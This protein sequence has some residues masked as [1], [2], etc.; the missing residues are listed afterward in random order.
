MLVE[1]ISPIDTRKQNQ[2]CPKCD[3]PAKYKIGAA[4]PTGMD[5]LG[6]SGYR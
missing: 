4:K 5:N 6:R 1:R 3:S 2:V